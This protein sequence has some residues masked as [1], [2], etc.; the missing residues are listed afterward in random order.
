MQLHEHLTEYRKQRDELQRQLIALT[1]A[2]QALER[3]QQET[4][5]GDE[6][7]SDKD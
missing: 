1:G 4:T 2:I 6:Q 3:L 7:N 5:D